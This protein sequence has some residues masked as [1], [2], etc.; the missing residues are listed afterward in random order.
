MG[1]PPSA[2]IQYRFDLARRVA[3]SGVRDTLAG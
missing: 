1:A 3:A 2:A